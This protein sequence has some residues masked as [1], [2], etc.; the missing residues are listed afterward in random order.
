MKG[1]EKTFI[2]ICLHVLHTKA[3]EILQSTIIFVFN[4][5]IL[6]EEKKLLSF[7][8]SSLLFTLPNSAF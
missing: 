4:S 3:L 7:K 5:K 1:F 2:F 6:S 8:L